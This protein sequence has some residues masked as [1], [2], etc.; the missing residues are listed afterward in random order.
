MADLE[1]IYNVPLSGAYAHNRRYRAR[2][3][4]HMLRAFLARHMKA[5]KENVRLSEELNHFLWQ[6]GMQAPPRK[7][8]LK[9]SKGADGMVK[10]ELLEAVKAVPKA[11]KPAEKKPEAKKPA[12][13]AKPAEKKAASAPVKPE[14]KPA[15]KA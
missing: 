13:A 4:V 14:P 5:G 1:R 12:P 10:A 8:R 15:K 9:A 3:A 7:V 6:H 11:V 2:R